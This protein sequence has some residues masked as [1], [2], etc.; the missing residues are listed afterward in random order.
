MKKKKKRIK[1][2]EKIKIVN[3][4]GWNRK[5]KTKGSSSKIISSKKKIRKLDLK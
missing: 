4:N 1:R 3:K 5:R 2:Y